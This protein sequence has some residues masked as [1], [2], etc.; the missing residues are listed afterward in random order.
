MALS[1]V[2]YRSTISTSTAVNSRLYDAKQAA[3]KKAA[4]LQKGLPLNENLSETM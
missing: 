3:E 2:L 1:T 4:H